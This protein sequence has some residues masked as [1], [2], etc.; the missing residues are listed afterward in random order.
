M[1]K[2]YFIVDIHGLVYVGATKKE[3]NER[4]RQHKYNKKKD[5]LCSSKLL[6]LDN[7]Y[8]ECIGHF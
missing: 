6:D 7:C 3:L 5:Y 1:I 8:I 4:M 2:I